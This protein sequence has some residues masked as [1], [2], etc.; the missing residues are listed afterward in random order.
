VTDSHLDFWKEIGGEKLCAAGR[1]A[2][3][4]QAVIQAYLTKNGCLFSL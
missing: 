2:V 1:V 3:I 4:D